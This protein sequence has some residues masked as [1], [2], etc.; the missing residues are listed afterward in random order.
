MAGVST[1]P[2]SEKPEYTR[3]FPMFNY[4]GGDFYMQ[5]GYS[6]SDKTIEVGLDITDLLTDVQ[7]G[8]EARYFLQ[9]VE[10]DPYGQGEGEIVS[11]SVMDYTDGAEEAI[12]DMQNVSIANSDTTLIWVNKTVDFDKVSIVTETLEPGAVGEPYSQQLEADMGTPPYEWSFKIEYTEDE[13]QEEY[14]AT[15]ANQ[16]EPSSDDDGYAILP[17]DFDFFF[18]GE[19]YDELTILTD[20]AIT[21]DGNFSYIRDDGAIAGN[22]CIAAYCSDLMIY[23]SQG[24]GIFYDGDETQMTIRWKAS[25]YG[26]P[27][28]DLEAAVQL[29]PDGTIRFFYGEDISAS[30]EWGSGISLGDGNNFLI[31]SISGIMN[32]PDGFVAEISSTP[33]PVGMEITTNGIFQGTPEL[34]YGYSWDIPFKVTDYNRISAIK[35]LVFETLEVGLGSET[36]EEASF[37][38][39]SP[40]P[41]T[42]QFSITTEKNGFYHFQLVDM[43]G[44]KV[45]EVFSGHLYAGGQV[46]W[47]TG[48][49]GLKAG[50]YFL[51]WT[52][53]HGSGTQKMILA[54]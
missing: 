40:N 10:Q 47:N 1:D 48:R 46:S 17:L 4:Q 36:T 34:E 30:P 9:I 49:T 5:G 38:Q 54:E 19:V 26:E 28:F 32:P 50:I 7:P 23:P 13:I 39:A 51:R 31:T 20:G 16:L 22:K 11:M 15:E 52:S 25:K 35:Y 44:K 27:S 12:S 45:A 37:V 21:F 29:F 18:Y 2:E 14:P 3:T 43:T 24:D 6:Q 8:A 41:F 53:T 33:F 42:E